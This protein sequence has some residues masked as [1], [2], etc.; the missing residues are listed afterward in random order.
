MTYQP[1]M[2]VND[3]SLSYNGK[4]LNISKQDLENYYE[5]GLTD[6]EIKSMA[7]SWLSKQIFFSFD[8]P[9]ATYDEL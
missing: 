3:W 4:T 2:F 5:N 6:D 9:T 7:F 8:P 1:F